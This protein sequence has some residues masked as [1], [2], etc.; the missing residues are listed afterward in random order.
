MIYIIQHVIAFRPEDGAVWN[1]TNTDNVVTLTTLPVRILCHLLENQGCIIDREGILKHVWDDYGLVPSSNSLNQHIS[2][3]RRTFSELGCEC[4]VIQTIPKK[5]LLI[6]SDS[7][8]IND[9]PPAPTSEKLSSAGHSSSKIKKHSPEWLVLYG[10]LL[11]V[12]FTAL[13]VFPLPG[14]QGI[15]FPQQNL[16]LAGKIGQCPVY[17]ADKSTPINEKLIGVVNQ[18]AKCSGDEVYVLFTDNVFLSHANGRVFLSRCAQVKGGSAVFS[19][20]KGVYLRER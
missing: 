11:L 4:E 19:N 12:I 3:I 7:V 2:Q 17:M 10:I 9:S 8:T 15:K 5:G 6:A 13:L 14:T 18:Y 1:V 16:V 20:C